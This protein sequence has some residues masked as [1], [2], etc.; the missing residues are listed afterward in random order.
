LPST[1]LLLPMRRTHCTTPAQ[2]FSSS[3]DKTPPPL[4]LYGTI[5]LLPPL[6]SQRQRLETQKPNSLPSFPLT[7]CSNE[8]S[9]LSSSFFSLFPP[10]R[11]N[12]SAILYPVPFP[13]SDQRARGSLLLLSLF[14]FAVRPTARA[15]LTVLLPPFFQNDG[16]SP[17]LPFLRG[18]ANG[19]TR[20]FPLFLH[21]SDR[22]VYIPSLPF[23]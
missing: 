2:L 16:G 10:N 1:L 9:S 4:D 12:G 8:R 11:K 15:L 14:F 23:L 5:P 17:L 18:I 22:I 13:S 19:R 20:L 7:I 6:P 21:D 3:V